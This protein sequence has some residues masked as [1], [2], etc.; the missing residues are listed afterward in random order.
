M[1][2]TTV[3]IHLGDGDGPLVLILREISRRLARIEQRLDEQL[4]T[5]V[6]VQTEGAAIM[7]DLSVITEE[8][9]QNGDAIGSAVAL[10][11]N[12]SQQIRDLSTD[13]AALQ[14]LADQLDANT[15]QLAEAVVAN[16]P[17]APAQTPVGGVPEQPTV[18]PD[19]E[20]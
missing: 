4:E 16:T 17:A 20:G 10:L 13:P 3:N 11:G 5:L 14:A 1:A 7:T 12:L 8:V 15:Q 18:E 9:A 19:E 6:Q 2:K